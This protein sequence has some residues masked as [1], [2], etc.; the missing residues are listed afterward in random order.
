MSSDGDS[1]AAGGHSPL[2]IWK[3]ILPNGAVRTQRRGVDD[4]TPAPILSRVDYNYFSASIA[5]RR[6]N[7]AVGSR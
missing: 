6:I 2:K 1:Q 3:N 4:H 5:D 7:A